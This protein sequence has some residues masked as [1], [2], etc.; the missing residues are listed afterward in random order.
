MQHWTV[1]AIDSQGDIKKLKV[2]KR[3]M[4]NL[5]NGEHIVVDFDDLDSPVGEGQDVLAEFCG[6]LAKD[7][8]IFLIHFE[9]W[10][11]LPATYFNRCFD[12][13]TRV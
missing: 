10:S 4:F 2:K 5:S 12:R 9:K 13:F 11:D 1:D 7:N 3:N 8:S 6:I